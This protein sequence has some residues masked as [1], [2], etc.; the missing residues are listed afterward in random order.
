MLAFETFGSLDGKRLAVAIRARR[1]RFQT[2]R[3][4][5]SRAAAILSRPS[6][7][8]PL[9]PILLGL[10]LHR[11]RSRVLHLEPVGGPAG[12]IN[13]IL[14]LVTV[15]N[16]TILPSSRSNS[17]SLPNAERH[18]AT[19]TLTALTLEIAYG[20]TPWYFRERYSPRLNRLRPSI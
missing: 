16:P 11:R 18:A 2:A 7:P 12:A 15:P 19:L 20:S 5:P 9:P 8:L 6:S 4:V 10:A 17:L 1:T 14:A 13:R 3:P